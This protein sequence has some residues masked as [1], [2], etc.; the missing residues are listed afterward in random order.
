MPNNLNKSV[1][2][3][4]AFLSVN[5]AVSLDVT[6]R[7]VRRVEKAETR[8]VVVRSDPSEEMKESSSSKSMF[9]EDE[10]FDPDERVGRPLSYSRSASHLPCRELAYVWLPLERAC[11]SQVPKSSKYLSIPT[12]IDPTSVEDELDSARMTLIVCEIWEAQV[13]RE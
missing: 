11:S 10:I 7:S 12:S 13:S 1:R 4:F 6:C 3:L 9:M 2:H 8:R 5:D